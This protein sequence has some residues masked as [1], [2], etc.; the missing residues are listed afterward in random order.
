MLDMDYERSRFE[1]KLKK[2][3]EN[4]DAYIE[5]A[6]NYDELLDIYDSKED[7]DTSELMWNDEND[8]RGYKLLLKNIWIC[9]KIIST[10][11]T[12]NSAG[13]DKKIFTETINQ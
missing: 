10:I 5:K 13:D 9:E 7:I 8:E 12:I 11:D 1:T 2:Y 3:E 6:V 4:L